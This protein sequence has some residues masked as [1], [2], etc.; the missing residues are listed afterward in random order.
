VFITNN[1]DLG[2]STI[3]PIYKDLWNIET[4]F[5]ALKQDLKNKYFVVSS[6][7][8]VKI[9]TCTSLIAMLIFRLL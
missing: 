5:K 3:A 1:H 2:A 7:N 9:H 6:D 4:L 8:A